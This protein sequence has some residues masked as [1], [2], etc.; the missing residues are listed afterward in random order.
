MAVD[1]GGAAGGL[2]QGKRRL[3]L[4]RAGDNFSAGID[5]DGVDRGKP[6]VVAIFAISVISTG[7]M[8]GGLES[9]WLGGRRLNIGDLAGGRLKDS[10]IFFFTLV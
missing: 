7:L 10:F 6:P 2:I 4:V 5:G 3:G 8:G 1:Q 9:G